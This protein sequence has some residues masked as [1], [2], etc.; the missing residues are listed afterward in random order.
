MVECLLFMG[1][2][3]KTRSRSKQ[4]GSGTLTFLVRQNV[5]LPVLGLNFQYNKTGFYSRVWFIKK[6]KMQSF[7]VMKLILALGHS[8]EPL[9]KITK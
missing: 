4:T 5:T 7:S 1:A 8:P 9:W 3:K 6:V 2:G